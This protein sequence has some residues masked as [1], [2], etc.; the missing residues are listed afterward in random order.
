LNPQVKKQADEWSTFTDQAQRN[1]QN[2]M[3]GFLSKAMKGDFKSI[4]AGFVD[5]LN[6][7]VA[8]ALAAKVGNAIFGTGEW[9]ALVPGALAAHG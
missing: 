7:M 8:D 1:I 4:E 3:S 6:N 2:S 5:M 9:L